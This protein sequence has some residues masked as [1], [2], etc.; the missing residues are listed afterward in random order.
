MTDRKIC[1]DFEDNRP[2]CLQY[3]DEQYTMKFDDIGEPPIY[4]CSN[5]GPVSH[6]M[7]SVIE[8]SFK[9]DPKFYDKFENA[10]NEQTTCPVCKLNTNGQFSVSEHI[11]SM[12]DT[13][14]NA[15]MV[16]KS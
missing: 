15:Y 6:A 5:C 12:N 7:L 14:H 13:D 11:R 10:I 8:D 1:R 16:H 9:S 3:A 2:G 4:W